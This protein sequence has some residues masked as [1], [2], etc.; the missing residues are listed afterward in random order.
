MEECIRNVRL[1]QFKNAQRRAMQR[2]IW[3]VKV[4]KEYKTTKQL[5]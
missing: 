2:N 1:V 3:F 4:I 5:K